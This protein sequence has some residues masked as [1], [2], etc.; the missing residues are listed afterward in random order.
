MKWLLLIIG[1]TL[2]SNAFQL[3]KAFGGFERP[4]QLTQLPTDR[5]FLI[6]QQ[7]GK[8]F[9][10]KGDQ[11]RVFLDLSKLVSRKSNEEGLLGIALS[12]HFKKDRTFFLNLTNKKKETEIW[13]FSFNAEQKEVSRKK[14]LS[15]KQLYRN[16]NGGWLG[17]GPDKM[18][19]IATGDGGSGNDPK[20]KAQ[21]LSSHLGKILRIEV[22]GKDTYTVPSDNPFLNT[23]GAKPE[24]YAYGLRNPWR[25][26]WDLKKKLFFI[27]DVG[28]NH[29]EELNVVKSSQLKG[30]N[31][32]WRLREGFNET[33]K[34]GVGG[35]SPQNTIDPV[36]EYKH[37][38]A[39]GGFSITGGQVYR[40][41]ASSLRGKYLFGDY[42]IPF[43]WTYDLK[44]KKIKTYQGNDLIKNRK[45]GEFLSL[46]ASF[47][48][49]LSGELYIISQEGSIYKV[50]N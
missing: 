38:A 41:S 24:I 42:V 14:L 17:F 31:F 32:G 12:P 40:G 33:P 15:F 47:D 3:E 5:S 26:F 49:D 22:L 13:R 29:Y 28:Q 44:T 39:E 9:Q 50:I 23:E 2:V 35:D 20:N 7:D 4:V 6:V 45:D 36:F 43:L 19:Y 37:D 11:K 10:V 46:I 21:D 48:S 18:L 25:C 8:I 27:A 30:A 16:H 34:K 1:L